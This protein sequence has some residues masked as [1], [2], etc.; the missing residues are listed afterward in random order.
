MCSAGKEW[1]ID[2]IS[3]TVRTRNDD[4]VELINSTSEQQQ[5]ANNNNQASVRAN[6]NRIVI[7]LKHLNSKLMDLCEMIP[8]DN[9]LLFLLQAAAV[10]VLWG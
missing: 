1:I 2:R 8:R 9:F 7:R 10:G 3:T 6:I 4:D 5:E